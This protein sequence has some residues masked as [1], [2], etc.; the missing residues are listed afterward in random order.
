MALEIW[1][2]QFR[3]SLIKHGFDSA[4]AGWLCEHEFCE[5]VEKKC[6]CLKKDP[7]RHGL[8]HAEIWESLRDFLP[9]HLR[10]DLDVKPL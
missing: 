9:E 5:I 2:E 8:M 10:H 1:L 3:A 4:Q 6:S 7:E